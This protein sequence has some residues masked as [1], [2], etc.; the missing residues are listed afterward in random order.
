MEPFCHS[1]STIVKVYPS[2]QISQICT[3]LLHY[4][5]LV[6]SDNVYFSSFFFASF[7][8]IFPSNSMI[9]I[10]FVMVEEM[11]VGNWI[12]YYCT[13]FWVSTWISKVRIDVHKCVPLPALCVSN[14]NGATEFLYTEMDSLCRNPFRRHIHRTFTRG[15]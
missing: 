2:I 1:F 8:R 7:K 4:R 10:M 13:V 11:I 3:E 6:I 9:D 12:P 14:M 15:V 5:C